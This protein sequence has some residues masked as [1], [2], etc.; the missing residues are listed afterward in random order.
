M[1][2]AATLLAAA[3][4]A[5][6][7]APALAAERLSDA[8]F[9]RANRCLGLTEAKALGQADTAALKALIKTQRGGRH[10]FVGDRADTARSEAARQAA[11]ADETARGAL[12]EERDGACKD[13]T[14]S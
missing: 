11:R 7:A 13:L 6:V 9:I 4:L 2:I 8:Q 10:T 12:V 1:R 5:A 3:S 14:A